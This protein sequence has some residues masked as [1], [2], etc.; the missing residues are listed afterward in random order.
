MT[1]LLALALLCSPLAAR[2]ADQKLTAAQVPAAVM[3]AVQAHYA[4]AKPVGWSK[5]VEKGKTEYEAKLDNGLEVTVS[6]AGKIM[7]E[8]S[9]IAFEQVPEAARQ[10]FAASKYG[11]WKV[12]KAEKVVEGDK[13][14]F[15]IAAHEGKAGVEVVLDAEGKILRE[16]R[17]AARGD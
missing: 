1:R 5:E 3:T 15:E 16:E 17:T 2:A 4:S 8:E 7:S 9:Q 13:T 10:A 6:P 11:K 12:R 14:S